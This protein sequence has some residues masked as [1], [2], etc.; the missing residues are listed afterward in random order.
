M[1]GIRRICF[2]M[3][4]LSSMRQIVGQLMAL[5]ALSLPGVAASQ[6]PVAD[7]TLDNPAGRWT[8]RRTANADVY[9]L[10]GSAAVHLMPHIVAGSERAIRENLEWLGEKRTNRRLN[11]FFVGSRDEM[12]PF[13]GTRSA[14][15]SVVAEGTA[16]FVA[17]DSASPALRHEVMHLLSWR[18]WGTPGGVWL[19]E[20]VATAAVRGCGPW[21]IAQAAASLYREGE[22]A[23]IADMRRRFATGGTRGAAHYLSAGS[24]VTFIDETWGRDRLR[25]LWQSGGLASSQAVLGISTLQLEQ[26]WRAH[27]V[28]EKPTARW[29]EMARQI[30]RAGCE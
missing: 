12:R 9:V 13:T 14:G 11:L 23:T 6:T 22:L 7:R 4:S 20:G 29:A 24:V 27:V 17:N 2:S 21:T 10:S 26:R 18:H 28:R 1:H 19:S 8:H 25:Q 5:L 3:I 15:W 30:A 16:F